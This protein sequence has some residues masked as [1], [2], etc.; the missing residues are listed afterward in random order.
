MPVVG[1]QRRALD[2]EAER[3]ARAGP[4]APRR[5]PPCGRSGSSPRPRPAP[6]AGARPARRA[7]TPRRRAGRSPSVNGMHAEHVDA[8]LPRSARP[9]APARSAPPGASPGRTTSDGCGSKV[10]TTDC[11]PS[12]RARF[13][14]CPMICLVPAVDAVE[15]ADRHHRAAP[16]ARRRLVPPPPLHRHP[17]RRPAPARSRRR[18]RPSRSDTIASTAP[19]GPEHRVR[20]G[21]ARPR[22]AGRRATAIRA[23]VRVGVAHAATTR[24]SGLRPAAGSPGR[25]APRARPA[26]APRPG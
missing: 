16:A 10:T 14:A 4:A 12:S 2:G 25:P 15:D 20:P 24:R 11:R 9:C 17:A 8:E 6:R 7:R 26:C 1:D 21:D 22:A 13:T 23:C 18:A 5:R 3:A 19:S